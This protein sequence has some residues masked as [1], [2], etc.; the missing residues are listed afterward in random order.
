MK[1]ANPMPEFVDE[2]LGAALRIARGE[3]PEYQHNEC[4]TSG[5]FDLLLVNVDGSS[6]YK[7]LCE[8]CERYG[9]VKRAGSDLKGYYLL[10]GQVARQSNTTEVPHGMELVVRDNPALSGELR[11]WYRLKG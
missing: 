1:A 6:A 2:L 4:F 7:L 11:D 8:L 10:L 3:V 9:A 5:A